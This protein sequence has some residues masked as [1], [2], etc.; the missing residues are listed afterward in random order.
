MY[1]EVARRI[2]RLGEFVRM[3]L[4]Y[5]HL[6]LLPDPFNA[7]FTREIVDLNSIKPGVKV[8]LQTRLVAILCVF[9]QFDV[10][11]DV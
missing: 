2:Q 6:L 10:I 8:H 7:G 5:W 1:E 3:L 11:H 9:G 4:A